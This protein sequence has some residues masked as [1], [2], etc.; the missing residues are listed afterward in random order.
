MTIKIPTISR[1]TIR[2]QEA[3]RER[4]ERLVIAAAYVVL[5]ATIAA[6]VVF[7][8][9]GLDQFITAQIDGARE[10]LALLEQERNK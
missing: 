2:R 7:E 4:R 6:A 3:R 10:F 8:A 5:F 9:G 1:A